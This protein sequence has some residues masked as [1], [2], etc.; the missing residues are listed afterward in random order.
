MT[1]T[2]KKYI[3]Y[4]LLS[5]MLLLDTMRG[6]KKRNPL[7]TL[8]FVSFNVSLEGTMVNVKC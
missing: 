1:A 8:L 4:N 5:L 7:L 2:G 6:K 3:Y